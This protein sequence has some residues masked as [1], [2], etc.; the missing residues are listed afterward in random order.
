MI[1]YVVAY[2]GGKMMMTAC[3]RPKKW[4]NFLPLRERSLFVPLPALLL[5]E[6][7]FIPAD[8]NIRA[9]GVIQ[10]PFLLWLA[11]AAGCVHAFLRVRVGCAVR[12]F[13]S[14]FSFCPRFAFI[15]IV[16]MVRETF[17]FI[18]HV[19]AL[20]NKI[21]GGEWPP[22]RLFCAFSDVKSDPYLGTTS[23]FF[24][25]FFLLKIHPV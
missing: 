4:I 9:A 14:I 13:R 16:M 1:I 2:S 5:K 8:E 24:F 22:H 18:P 11:A 19:N 10:Q 7:I 6:T 12:A 3:N 17:F 23:S 25:S 20:L 15:Y 21:T